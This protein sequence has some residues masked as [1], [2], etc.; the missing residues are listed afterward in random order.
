[1]LT[2]TDGDQ[3]AATLVIDIIDDVPTA[4]PDTDT[5]GVGGFLASGNVITDAALGD[6]GDTDTN[7]ADTV[8]ADDAV[9]TFI[10]SVN[11]APGASVPNG[12]FTDI[13]GQYGTLRIF[14]NGD[15][16]Y[17]RSPESG[18]GKQDVF[19]Y[20]LTDGDGDTSVTTLTIDIPN[21]PI[22]VPFSIGN[23]LDDDA[24][25]GGNPDG[26]ED[27]G[28]GSF[29]EGDV[30]ANGGDGGLTY[31][32]RATGAP[33]GFT[34]ELAP[35]GD[36]LI[37]QDGNLVVTVT[38]NSTTGHW[39]ITQNAPIDHPTLNGEIGDDTENNLD[40]NITVRATDADGDFVEGTGLL[41]ID[42]DTPTIIASGAEPQLV[43]DETTLGTNASASFAGAFITS[44]GADT[45]GSTAYALH[46]AP[47]GVA[48]GLFDVA[49]GNQIY[50]YD[51]GGTI[52]GK[53]GSGIATPNASGA[54][55][56]VVTVD[57]N[58]LVTLD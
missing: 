53:V 11:A 40:F 48:S 41:T 9:V 22:A 42:D 55:S 27:D 38:L 44:V 46:V 33:E 36:L 3:A 21:T 56:F 4:R 2:D 16:L 32:L 39:T 47:G 13:A 43:V 54:T 26:P 51:V 34:Y 52:V 20:T 6:A 30:N 18:G 50:L 17:T 37:K 23:V 5:V 14:S 19:N 49:T 31:S 29:L 10:D 15:Y 24:Q 28:G 7:A 25:P 8:G 58:G 12:G 35:N 1:M 57:S 45:P